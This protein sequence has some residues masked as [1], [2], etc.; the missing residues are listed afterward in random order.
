MVLSPCRFAHYSRLRKL[1]LSEVESPLEL[2]HLSVVGGWG[3]ER[4]PLPKTLSLSHLLLLQRKV[5]ISMSSWAPAQEAS[6]SWS[7]ERCLLSVSARGESRTGGEKVRPPPHTHTHFYSETSLLGMSLL[8][9]AKGRKSQKGKV[10]ARGYGW[11]CCAL[12]LISEG[13]SLGVTTEDLW[14]AVA[15]LCTFPESTG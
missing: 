10:G 3:D 9:F 5:C 8:Q 7:L 6:S 15:R 11:L 12:R 13:Q 1:S 14:E 4:A 2:F